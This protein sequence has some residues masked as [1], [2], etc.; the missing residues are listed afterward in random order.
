[1]HIVLL[2]AVL[3]AP[4]ARISVSITGVAS[5]VFFGALLYPVIALALALGTAIVTTL[6]L[7]ANLADLAVLS[8][9]EIQSAP[10]D[11]VGTLAMQQIFGGAGL[12]LR[13]GRPRVAHLPRPGPGPRDAVRRDGAADTHR[14]LW[15]TA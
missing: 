11:R 2:G 1:M 3:L 6:Y 8:L 13:P 4:L 14:H 15:P 9:P 12:F 7:L 10:Q 5:G